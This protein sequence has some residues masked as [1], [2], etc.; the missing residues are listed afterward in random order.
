MTIR[1]KDMKPIS[2]WKKK[3]K[4]V[5]ITTDKENNHYE[6]ITT[7]TAITIHKLYR[8]KRI[9]TYTIQLNHERTEPACNCPD[10]TYRHRKCKHELVLEALGIKL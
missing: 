8:T 5:L 1:Y 2:R 6:I 7:P 10:A 9:E 4:H 3:N